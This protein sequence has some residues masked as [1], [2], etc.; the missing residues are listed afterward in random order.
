[1]RRV[2]LPT[3]SAI[4]FCKQRITVYQN[5]I[6]FYKNF[7]DTVKIWR[8]L[9]ESWRISYPEQDDLYLPDQHVYTMTSASTVMRPKIGSSWCPRL[10]PS[11]SCFRLRLK[12]VEERIIIFSGRGSRGPRCPYL[13]GRR[14]GGCRWRP[15]ASRGPFLGGR[16]RRKIYPIIMLQKILR[17][18]FLHQF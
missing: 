18:Q 9:H 3:T 11:Q 6:L 15:A 14:F 10:I 1:M 17:K 8:P 12:L 4:R 2:K 7:I 13:P 5:D 16:R